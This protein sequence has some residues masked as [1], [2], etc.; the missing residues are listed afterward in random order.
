MNAWCS[1]FAAGAFLYLVRDLGI[2]HERPQ[3]RLQLG[4]LEALDEIADRRQSASTS[5]SVLG[6]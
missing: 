5:L 3:Q 1:D 2:G 4:I 6:R